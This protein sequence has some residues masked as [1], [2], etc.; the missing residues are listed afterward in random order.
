MIKNIFYKIMADDKQ[1]ERMNSLKDQ[2]KIYSL[3]CENGYTKSF[4][5]FKIEMK[6]FLNSDDS[7]KIVNNDFHELSDE[8]LEMVAGG[9]SV[10]KEKL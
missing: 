7:L 9:L 2:N 8:A 3:F 1:R 5:T 10:D 4:D 6:D